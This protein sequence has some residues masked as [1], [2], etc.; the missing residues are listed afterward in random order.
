MLNQQPF[1]K[2]CL[3]FLSCF[4]GIAYKEFW[5][6]NF[7]S[8]FFQDLFCQLD[9]RLPKTD[10]VRAQSVFR[11]TFT[12][13]MFSNMVFEHQNQNSPWGDEKK[14]AFSNFFSPY[15]MSKG[16]YFLYQHCYH[17]MIWQFLLK[18]VFRRFT[19]RT[20]QNI[21]IDYSKPQSDISWLILEGK[22]IPY[23]KCFCLLMDG[24]SNYWSGPRGFRNG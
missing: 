4:W 11:I 22:E 16:I 14:K 3:S 20:R 23:A 5:K 13:K 17:L 10:T 8:L 21:L 18:N 1:R 9:T 7:F 6:K 12:V 19:F 2:E 15:K 24:K